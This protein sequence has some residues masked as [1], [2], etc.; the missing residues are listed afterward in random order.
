MGMTRQKWGGS[1][2]TY[3]INTEDTGQFPDLMEKQCRYHDLLQVPINCWTRHFWDHLAMVILRNNQDF[4]YIPSAQYRGGTQTKSL[5]KDRANELSAVP[6]SNSAHRDQR[7]EEQ[8]YKR[9]KGW[10]VKNSPWFC[11]YRSWP[12]LVFLK[13]TAVRKCQWE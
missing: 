13:Q 5:K 9:L 2:G 4:S 8:Y 7:K 10:S 1:S 6:L 3:T 12:C 11:G